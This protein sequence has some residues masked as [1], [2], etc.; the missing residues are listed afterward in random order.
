[1]TERIRRVFYNFIRRRA[2]RG[3]GTDDDG[4][5]GSQRTQREQAQET[6]PQLFP[7]D[8]KTFHEILGESLR[9]GRKDGCLLV[10]DVD[11]YKEIVDM[12]GQDGGGAV[13]RHAEE[14]F[15]SVFGDSVC[16]GSP[17]GGKYVLWL[18]ETASADA[19]GVRRQI[20][21]VNDR[22]LHPAGAA[23]PVSVSA[24]A[25]F[26]N[27]KDDYKA[28]NKRAYQMLYLVKKNGSCGCEVSL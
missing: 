14:V 23:P 24:G 7:S 5:E 11:R 27:G 26:C 19:G 28:L 6:P 10:C 16:I 4:T 25:A 20:G 13:L 15:R 8:W 12:C 22:L 1:M 3:G 9:G 21:V 2:A 18:P 17:G